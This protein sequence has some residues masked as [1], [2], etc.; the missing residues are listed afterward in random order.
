MPPLFPFAETT[1]LLVNVP[2]TSRRTTPP[3]FAPV[4]A[5]FPPPPEAPNNDGAVAEP[6]DEPPVPGLLPPVPL[7][8]APPWP[9]PP[10]PSPQRPEPVVAAPG[11]QMFVE[12]FGAAPVSLVARHPCPSALMTPEASTVSVEKLIRATAPVAALPCKVKDP[13]LVTCT[14]VAVQS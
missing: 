12:V 13:V 1:P 4:G 3:P 9:P 14:I 8:P 6:Y 11:E 2:D 5:V 7:P 10:A